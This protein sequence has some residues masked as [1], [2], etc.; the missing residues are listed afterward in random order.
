[1]LS[2][3]LPTFL[4]IYAFILLTA[5]VWGIKRKTVL[6]SGLLWL[7]IEVLFEL[8]QSPLVAPSVTA[9]IPD[10]FS[11]ISVLENLGAYFTRGTFD[12]LDL[13]AALAGCLSA[14]LTYELIH[15][16][17]VTHGNSEMV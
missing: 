9:R 2:Q 13:V 11:E 17:E 1:M 6:F 5:L 12:P 10:W 15:S 16:K 14:W 8:G 3:W 4:H 7:L